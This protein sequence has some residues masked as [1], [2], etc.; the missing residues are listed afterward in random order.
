LF[1]RAIQSLGE[2]GGRAVSIDYSPFREAANM[3]YSGPWVAERAAALKPFF[4]RSADAAHPVTRRIIE[5]S[6]RFSAVET[7]EA[8]YRLAE[9]NRAAQQTWERVPVM[10]LPTAGTIYSIAEVEAEPFQLNTNLGYYTNFVNLLDCCAVSVPVGFTWDG[11]P[12]GISLIGPAGQDATVLAIAR[13]LHRL[14]ALPM[15]ATKTIT[16]AV[17]SSK[18]WTSIAVAGAHLRGLPLNGQLLAHG[19]RFVRQCRTAPIYRLYEIA[20]SVPRKPGLVRSLGP[21]YPIEVELWDLP[22]TGFGR[23]VAGVP[24]P[25]GTGT[26]IIESGEPVQGL[27]CESGLAGEVDISAYGG[28]RQYLAASPI[29]HD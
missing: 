4:A 5:G 26:V 17:T 12:F 15:G 19:G 2:L 23:F 21:G 1:E 9:L 18:D 27:L 3:L 8:F 20:D 11:L 22:L 13:R 6:A 14:L 16:P 24:S 29:P 7:F 25:L 10:L 28:W